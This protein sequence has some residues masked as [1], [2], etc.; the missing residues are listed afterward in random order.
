[1][2]AS[3]DTGELPVVTPEAET[4][5]P[6]IP[7][8]T[9]PPAWFVSLVP[10][11]DSL[12]LDFDPL[13]SAPSTNVGAAVDMVSVQTPPGSAAVTDAADAADAAEVAEATDAAD[14]AD[15]AEV[16]E[17]TDAAEVAQ[18]A[19][20]TELPAQLIVPGP[21]TAPTV[22]TP[23]RVEQLRGT[24]TQ[25]LPTSL[26]VL[27]VALLLAL[28]VLLDVARDGS[29]GLPSTVLFL[30][31]AVGTPLVLRPRSLAGGVVLPP[32]AF[33]A[34]AA[35]IAW[36][37]GLNQGSG[38][39][40]LD[41]GTTMALHAPLIFAGTAAALLVVLTRVTVRLVRR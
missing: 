34:T 6:L 10:P 22:A 36:R 19:K 27:L 25:G 17:A 41:A 30:L 9:D 14:A 29:F 28:G 21:R 24:W 37:S 1:V 11:K 5:G 7:S 15:A 33:A 4:E 23:S 26:V 3:P 16:A 31:A 20:P 38:Q 32:L 39:I 8:P 13:T 2:T 18:A 12:P 35:A 40:G